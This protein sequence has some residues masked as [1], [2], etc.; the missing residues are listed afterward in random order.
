MMF[1]LALLLGSQGL[2]L[3]PITPDVHDMRQSYPV[4]KRTET[5]SVCYVRL[6][7]GA[8]V[9]CQISA[10]EVPAERSEMIV[11]AVVPVTDWSTAPCAPAMDGS[12]LGREDAPPLKRC[13]K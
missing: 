7:N 2:A 9:P 4:R 13:F 1:E 8:V 11:E 5:S 3:P 10:P 12:V 6:P